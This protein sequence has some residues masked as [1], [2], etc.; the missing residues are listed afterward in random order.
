MQEEDDERAA[1]EY[2]NNQDHD[3]AVCCLGCGAVVSIGLQEFIDIHWRGCYAKKRAQLLEHELEFQRNVKR[4][5]EGSDDQQCQ[6]QQQQQ[7]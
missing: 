2:L 7:Q 1:T 6:Q 4:R 3:G 5:L